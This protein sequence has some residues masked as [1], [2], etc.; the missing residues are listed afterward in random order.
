MSSELSDRELAQFQNRTL[1]LYAVVTLLLLLGIGVLIFYVLQLG[2]LTAPGNERSFGLAVSLMALMGATLFHLV[3]R[4]YRS[5]PLG[6]RFRPSQPAVY[7]TDA[8]IRFLKIVVAV[9]A[10]A[11]IAYLLG[12][13][14]A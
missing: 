12:S 11:A 14:L 9:A 10:A 7:G 3:D 13:L 2:S 4:A 1:D 8:W 5:W 6:R